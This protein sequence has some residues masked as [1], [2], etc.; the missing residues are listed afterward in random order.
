MCLKVRR[1]EQL[2]STHPAGKDFHLCEQFS[3]IRFQ[4]QQEVFI[5]VGFSV[6]GFELAQ[7]W[8]EGNLEFVHEVGEDHACTATDT[9]HAVN[10]D[11][12][13]TPYG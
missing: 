8:F 10:Q 2:R 3:F 5:R 12:P 13:S 11:L 7:G 4:F 6:R 9:V 1:L